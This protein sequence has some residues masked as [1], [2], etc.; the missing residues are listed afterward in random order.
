MTRCRECGGALTPV[1]IRCNACGTAVGQPGATLKP[2]EAAIDRAIG[3]FAIA[4]IATPLVLGLLFFVP[5]FG[6][7]IASAWIVAS[8]SIHPFIGVL[9]LSVGVG[10][11]AGIFTFASAHRDA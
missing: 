11:L 3:A 6:F 9:L 5:P 2:R 4:F 10:L 8:S 7:L 1:T